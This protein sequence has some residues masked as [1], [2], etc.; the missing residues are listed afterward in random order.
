MNSDICRCTTDQNKDHEKHFN[1]Q[2]RLEVKLWFKDA[3]TTRTTSADVQNSE[4]LELR[5]IYNLVGLSD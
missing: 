2:E 3:E 1:L 5:K 4:S